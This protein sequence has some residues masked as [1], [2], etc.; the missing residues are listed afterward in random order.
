LTRHFQD[1]SRPR[2]PVTSR[3]LDLPRKDLVP[4]QA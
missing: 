2:L 4:F 3:L 1:P